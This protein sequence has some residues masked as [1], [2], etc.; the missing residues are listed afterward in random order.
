MRSLEKERLDSPDA[1]KEDIYASLDF[2]VFVNRFFGGQR[3]ILDFLEKNT[4]PSE[5]TVLDLG[6][7][8]GDIAFAITQWAK[9]QGKK[10]KIT[11]LD[12]NPHCLEYSRSHFP[13][14]NINFL[15]HSAFDLES[16]GTFDFIISSMFF[17]HLKNDE[18]MI[19]LKKM[20]QYSRIG[21]IINDL[22]RSKRSILAAFVLSLFSFRKI[23][24]NDA[25]L[26]VK[27]AFKIKDFDHI[28]QKTSINLIIKRKPIF[29]IVAYAQ[30]SH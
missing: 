3:A 27:R 13:S 15:N 4:A 19:L 21:F 22:Y 5:F 26:S 2:M 12:I 20:S 29:R 25:T 17:H 11:A 9:T 14:K 16:L 23:V 28:R 8:S 7:G 24:V 1:P 30:H 6:S 18:I 10:V